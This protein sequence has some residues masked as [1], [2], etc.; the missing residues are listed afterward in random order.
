MHLTTAWQRLLWEESGQDLIEYAL[1][2]GICTLGSLAIFASIRSRMEGA[3]ISW[4]AQG[5]GNWIPARPIT[6]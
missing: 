3:Y 6:P 1:L 2:T 5:Q 4:E